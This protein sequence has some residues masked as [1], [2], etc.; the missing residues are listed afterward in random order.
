MAV[1]R[2]EWECPVCQRHFAIRA[3]MP[4]P[5]ACPECSTHGSAAAQATAIADT[6]ICEQFEFA[7]TAS[8]EE[9]PAQ[10]SGM[11]SRTSVRSGAPDAKRYRALHVMTLCFKGFAGL[12]AAAGVA[13]LTLMALA[14]FRMQNPETRSNLI[15]RHLSEFAGCALATL[16]LWCSAE[17][18]QLLIDIEAN[19]RRTRGE[20]AN[21]W[22]R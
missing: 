6:R 19:T 15:L 11:E 12:A 21:E 3:D 5:A 7:A 9:L 22:A 4:R 1:P 10:E 16:V 17:L 14:A 8:L 13:A 18:I 20:R 2:V